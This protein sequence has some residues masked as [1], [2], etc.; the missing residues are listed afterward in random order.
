[1]VCSW[2][3]RMVGWDELVRLRF[4]GALWLYRRAFGSA[5]GRDGRR[6]PDSFGFV[7]TILTGPVDVQQA[8]VVRSASKALE[9]WKLKLGGR[10][11]R[12]TSHVRT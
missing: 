10:D 3:E 5:L 4:S 6:L 11:C 2:C 9:M 1:M 7:C 12:A 8:L